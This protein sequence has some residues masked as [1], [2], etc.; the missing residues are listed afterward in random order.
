MAKICQK[1]WLNLNKSIQMNKVFSIFIVV[2]VAATTLFANLA[3]AQSWQESINDFANGVVTR[4]KLPSI[5]I[6]VGHQDQIIFENAYGVSDLETMKP[7]SIN[8]QYRTASI[9]KWLTGTATMRLVEN[10]AIDLNTPIQSY[11]PEYPEK[12]WPITTRQLLSHTAGIRHYVDFNGARHRAKTDEELNE[13]E[14][15][16]AK[17][18][19]SYQTR[20]T[21]VIAP[22]DAFKNDDLIYEPGTRHRYTSFGYRVLG[23]VIRGAVNMPYRDVMQK[24]IFGPTGMSKTVAEDVDVLPA[25]TA[26]FYQFNGDGHPE[27]ASPRDVSENLPAGGHLSTASDLVR[28]AIAFDNEKLVNNSSIALMSS[29]PKDNNDDDI[30]YAGYGHGVDFMGAFPGSLGHG[31]TQEGTT[32]LIILLPEESLSIAVMTN[33]SGWRNIN[34]FTQQILEYVRGGV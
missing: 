33:I 6:A 4:N 12:P 15:W 2:F 1:E 28:F 27:P 26:T 11:C 22:L 16:I 29:L 10:G 13:I 7:A 31:G 23:C 8:T 20:Y 21:D 9:S 32:T 17:L 34:G 24:Y 19:E 5:Q 14:A 30:G 25:D 3:N 18:E